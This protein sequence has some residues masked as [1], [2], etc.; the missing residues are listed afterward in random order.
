MKIFLA[1]I[2]AIS[3]V[4]AV[5]LEFVP[6]PSDNPIASAIVS[7]IAFLAFAGSAVLFTSEHYERIINGIRPHILPG[8]HRDP[9]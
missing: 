7:I 4:V 8:I 5:Y 3:F 9:N 1:V 2:T 6:Y